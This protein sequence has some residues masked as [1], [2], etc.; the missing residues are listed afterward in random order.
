MTIPDIDR[1]P[2]TDD[3]YPRPTAGELTRRWDVL[4]SLAR[5]AGAR[6][7]VVAGSGA[8]TAE[9]Q[10]LTNVAVRW[11]SL[12][13]ASTDPAVPPRLLLQLDNHAAGA[14]DWAMVPIAITGPGLASAAIAWLTEHIG[15]ADTVALLGP[16]TE[17]TAGPLRSALAGHPIVDLGPVF[18]RSR[19]VKGIEELSWVAWA[20][21]ACDRAIDAFRAEAQPGMREDELAALLAAH[22]VRLGAQPGICFMA[23]APAGGGEAVVP[24]QVP[25]RRRTAPGDTLTFE[26]SAGMCGVTTQVLRTLTLGGEPGPETRHVHAVA[27]ATFAALLDAVRPGVTPARLETIGGAIIE[28][29]G[30]TIVDDLVHGYG[31]GYLPPVLRT[32]GTRR[33]PPPDLPLVPGMLLV[34]QPNVVSADR[35]VGVQTGELIAV[36]DDGARMFHATPR[37]LL[38]APTT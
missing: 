21:D 24:R 14:G 30:M 27:D 15:A 12:L 37:G 17:R 11:E 5:D 26:L 20:A 34:L 7:I 9:I 2:W 1:G 16:I 13:V 8:G 6:G 25:G 19:L 36:T 18:Q 23:T 3:A 28:G 22:V 32:P 33:S 29:A 10:H 35:R 4:R 38:A 31:G